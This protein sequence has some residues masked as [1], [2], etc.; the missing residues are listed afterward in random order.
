MRSRILCWSLL[1]VFGL[2]SAPLLAQEPSDPTAASRQRAFQEL[3]GVIAETNNLTDK[4]M[5]VKVRAKAANL[6]WLHDPDRARTIFREL[7][8]MVEEQTDASFDRETARTDLLK[9]LFPRERDMARALLEK[10]LGGHK[11]EEAPYRAQI[12]GTD[13]NVTRLVRLSA[14]LIEQ[15]TAMA[16]ALLERSLSV[17][18]SPMALFTLFRLRE[19]DPS[20]ADYI[21]ARTLEIL[22]VRPTVIALPGVYVLSDY[23]FPSMQSFG[24]P[25]ARPPDISL[26]MQYISTAYE[27]LQKSLV[28]SESALQRE[29]RYTEKDLRFRR[30]YQGQVAALL[31]ALAPRYAPG[32]VQEL[33]ERAAT[34][35]AD[36]P[37]ETMR[38]LRFNIARI[39]GS[40][41]EVDDLQTAISVAI[42]RGDVDGALRALEKLEDKGTKKALAQAVA[43]VEFRS[44]LAKSHFAEALIAARRIEDPN[45]RGSLY[46]QVARAAHQSGEINFSKMIL[47]EAR[48][49]LSAPDP[50]GARVLTLLVLASEASAISAPEAV[51]LLWDAVS[52]LN[53]LKPISGAEATVGQLARV[54]DPRGFSDAMELW[55][56]FSSVGRV[57]LEG[58]LW[59][60]NQIREEG[61][62]LIAR[63]AAC[64]KWLA[65]AR[66][67]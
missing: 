22:R 6:L 42:A 37:P 29:G 19:R 36:L 56:A 62:R 3:E 5:Y 1:V 8:K 16:A 58:A 46:A 2:T 53:A 50:N 40:L 24:K 41:R 39:T 23:M 26:L 44:H 59:A 31:S 15:D 45:L 48:A 10:T 35:A 57:D 52:A 64:H 54:H 27:I 60:A 55:Q 21:V 11:S 51:Q 28:E 67:L 63:L 30:V 14:E 49:A 18:V 7:W 43:I 20:L 12:A 9:N 65:E 25:V 13:Q 17:S 4:L 66:E 34:L 47:I 38:L 61:V 33:N 32:L